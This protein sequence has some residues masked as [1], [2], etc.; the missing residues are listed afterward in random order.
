MSKS[1]S[2]ADTAKLIRQALKE[3]FPGV[4]FSVRSSTYSG[5]ASIYVNWTDGPNVAQVEAV[6]KTFSGAYFDGMQDLKGST[7]ALLD[8]EV[9]RFG[10]DF[11]FSNRTH[12]PA[13]VAKACASVARL[14]GMATVPCDQDFMQGRLHGVRINDGWGYDVA[15][16]VHQNLSKRSDRLAVRKSKTAAR[17]IYLGNDGHSD[18]GALQVEVAA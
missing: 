4:K 16:L 6:S 15:Q 5:G 8:G 11:I 9:V 10:A 1:I 18:H 14:Y 3:A 7:Y 2:C 12:S 17:V 13:L